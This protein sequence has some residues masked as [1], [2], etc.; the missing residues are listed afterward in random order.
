MFVSMKKKY[1]T[2]LLSR[3]M[4]PWSVSALIDASNISMAVFPTRSRF[5]VRIVS[6]ITGL[7]KKVSKAKGSL[8]Q[9]KPSSTI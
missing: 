8:T 1:L 7:M 2:W 5:A 6:G 9:L 4:R 3:T